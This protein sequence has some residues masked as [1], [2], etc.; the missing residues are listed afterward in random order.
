MSTGE[1]VSRLTA[2]PVVYPGWLSFVRHLSFY[3]R[4][5]GIA[6]LICIYGLC[7]QAVLPAIL[8]GFRHNRHFQRLLTHS[9]IA[10][11]LNANIF[12]GR[13]D[14]KTLED[15]LIFVLLTMA[16]HGGVYL[17]LNSFFLLCDAT[18]TFQRYK[19][20][21]TPRMRTSLSLLA[22][23]IGEAAFNHLLVDPLAMFL[24]YVY[25]A[26]FHSLYLTP[27][28]DAMIP[29]PM[30]LETVKHMLIASI[31]NELLFYWTH[32]A[33]HEV[34]GLYQRIHKQH[35]QYVGSVCAAGEFFHPIERAISGQLP[36]AFY[37]IGWSRDVGQAVWLTWAAWRL[38]EAFEAHSGYC[39]R[40]SALTE[41]GLTFSERAE[42]HDWHHTDN[43]GCYGV[44]WVD[45]LFGTMDSYAAFLARGGHRKR[46]TETNALQRDDSAEDDDRKSW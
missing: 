36:T 20:P 32:R 33:L 34:P 11:W 16:V 30:F 40:G 37:M 46:R 14:G 3:L 15:T 2:E 44:Y 23:T 39:F 22:R 38:W 19:L 45:Y 41:I 13:T 43:R 31:C 21:R 26:D 8:R 25:V 5:S 17:L 1:G 42:F 9:P 29:R 6:A 18:G 24:V 4:A 10:L 35:H 7:S 28:S 27:G 12:D